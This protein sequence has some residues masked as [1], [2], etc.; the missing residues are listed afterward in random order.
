MATK[1]TRM[2]H[3]LATQL[4][5]L[6][7]NWTIRSSRS[8]RPVRKLMDT[9]SYLYRHFSQL[10]TV[11]KVNM[12]CLSI[13]A[14]RRIGR[15]DVK[16]HIFSILQRNEWRTKLWVSRSG[17]FICRQSASGPHWTGGWMGPQR[18][19]K[20]WQSVSKTL[21]HCG[22]LSEHVNINTLSWKVKTSQSWVISPLFFTV[23]KKV[24]VDYR[25]SRV[26]FPAGAGNFALPHRVQNGSGTHPASYPMC[27]RGS[28]PG[29]KA[30]GAWSWPLT[31]IQRRGQR[32]RGAISPLPNTPSW[33]GAQFKKK[34]QTFV[35]RLY[36]HDTVWG[37][38]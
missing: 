3:K 25:C 15:T 23:H 35:L 8:R 17:W 18:V 19:L 6:A 16:L 36:Q 26:R 14:W 13:M 29:G 12:S 32:M 2:T 11:W 5:L 22:I 1:L 37:N 30:A 38:F 4:Q 9:P 34:K 21:L 7:E 28:Y 20:W 27:T 24:N 33:R 31:S 10:M